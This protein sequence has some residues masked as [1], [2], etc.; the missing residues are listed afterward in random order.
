[1]A[2]AE[3]CCPPK[4]GNS[5]LQILDSKIWLS[6]SSEI[7]DP[8]TWHA[9]PC[10]QTWQVATWDNSCFIT[11]SWRQH[12][13]LLR[14]AA[15]QP[16]CNLFTVIFFLE[17]KISFSHVIFLLFY[18]CVKRSAFI[19]LFLDMCNGVSLYFLTVCTFLCRFQCRFSQS[20]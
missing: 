1:M 19:V 2:I 7:S 10:M 9:R 12:R 16:P 11:K 14:D 17:L 13:L 18:R 6:N 5:C 20:R 3:N 4:M 15:A 8:P